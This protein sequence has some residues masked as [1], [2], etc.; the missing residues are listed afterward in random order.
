MKSL[1]PTP[2]TLNRWLNPLGR[3]QRLD[4]LDL[5]I[6]CFAVLAVTLGFS[7]LVTDWLWALFWPV[8]GVA[9]FAALAGLVK[10][11][12]DSG[13]GRGWVLVPL[14]LTPVAAT[15]L[16]VWIDDNTTYV[17]V[18]AWHFS[19]DQAAHPGIRLLWLIF[20]SDVAG[21]FAGWLLLVL[22]AAVPPSRPA[23]ART[24]RGVAPARSQA[25]TSR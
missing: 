16:A 23:S 3:M 14:L 9:A 25:T 24:M 20:D 6:R 5:E 7:L 15:W 12:H 13:I 17:L 1:W 2:V 18:H 11:L 21:I 8:M 22:A 4:Y 19:T 10:R